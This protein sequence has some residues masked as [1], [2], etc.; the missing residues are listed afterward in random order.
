MWTLAFNGKQ[1]L[2]PFIELRLKTKAGAKFAAVQLSKLS[3]HSVIPMRFK[4]AQVLSRVD[5]TTELPDTR[6]NVFAINLDDFSVLKVGNVIGSHIKWWE[7]HWEKEQV[8][9]TQLLF[10]AA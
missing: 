7:E 10:L 4:N 2:V 1:G 3:G 6:F 5:A 8:G 9:N